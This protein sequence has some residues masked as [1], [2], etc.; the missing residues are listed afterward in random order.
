VK[1]WEPVIWVRKDAS[2]FIVPVEAVVWGAITKGRRADAPKVGRGCRHTL[3]VTAVTNRNRVG[4]Q[5]D[6]V[7]VCGREVARSAYTE[8]KV[9]P[10]VEQ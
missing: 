9:A 2:H 3:T 8:A 6:Y 10:V 1:P 5:H 4:R 7:G